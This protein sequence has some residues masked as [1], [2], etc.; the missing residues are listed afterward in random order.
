MLFAD[1][2]KLGLG[3]LGAK[4]FRRRPF[5]PSLGTQGDLEGALFQM[6]GDSLVNSPAWPILSCSG[7]AERYTDQE[8]QQESHRPLAFTDQPNRQAVG[9][10]LAD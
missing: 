8:S 9:E 10:R 2:Y 7:L 5:E 4:P 3:R 1:E 6:G